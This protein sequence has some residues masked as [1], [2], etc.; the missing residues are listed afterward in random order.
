MPPAGRVGDKA[1]CPADAH[2]CSACAH[3]VEGP[4]VAGSPDVFINKK[5]ALRVQDPG[6]HS[7][8]C[9][10]NTWS[11]VAGAAAVIINGLEA[12]RSGDATRHC[13]GNGKL[14]EGSPD[15]IIGD[16]VWSDFSNLSSAEPPPQLATSVDEELTW[17]EVICHYEDGSPAAH[18]HFKLKL[19]DG[20]TYEATLDRNGFARV[21]GIRPGQCEFSLV[22]LDK[23]RWEPKN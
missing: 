14:V 5:A 4:A 12:H 10:S 16:D 7:A 2:G 18:E 6:V 22:E 17:I 8:C 13:G 15:V 21:Q 11:A 23:R 20:T 1:S 9:G 19:S 3:S